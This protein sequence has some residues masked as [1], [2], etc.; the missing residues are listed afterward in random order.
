MKN[1]PNF[2]IKMV[3]II[4]VILLAACENSSDES[5]GMKEQNS[6]NSSTEKTLNV[7]TKKEVS[8]NENTDAEIVDLENNDKSENLEVST[9]VHKNEEEI[10]INQSTSMKEEYL[11]KLSEAKNEVERIRN[12]KIDDT[13]LALKTA[14]GEVYEILDGL[15][16]EVYGVLKEQLPP[17]EMEQ[18]RNE[19]REWIKYRDQTAKEASLKYEGGTLEQLEYLMVRNNLT[20]E[21]CLELVKNYMK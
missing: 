13:M 20:E 14:E 21:R 17:E 6:Q 7:D 16:N 9:D 5:N 19:Q 8:E 10:S 1:R 4:L 2:I 12:N 15:L 18:L 11:K 3:T